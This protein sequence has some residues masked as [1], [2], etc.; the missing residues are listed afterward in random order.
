VRP[1]LVILFLS[2]LSHSASYALSLNELQGSNLVTLLDEDGDSA[3]WI[4]LFNPG[5][6]DLDLTDYGLSDREDQPFRWIFPACL[7]PADSTIL[8]FASGK[9]RLFWMPH[10]ETILDHHDL[11]KYKGGDVEPPADWREIGFDDGEWDEGPTGIGYGDG[12]DDTIISW[13]IKTWYTRKTFTVDE[14]SQVGAVAFHVDYDDG[15]VAYL[16]GV[17]I[18]RG[19]MGDPGDPPPHDAFAESPREATIFLGNRPEAKFFFDNSLLVEGENVLA[20]QVHNIDIDSMDLSLI[21]FLTLGMLSE[22]E[23]AR[24]LSET[25]ASQVPQLHAS[26]ELNPG[27]ESVFLTTPAGVAL[28]QA[29]LPAHGIDHS[30]G[31]HPDGV[32][33]WLIFEEPS[34]WLLN[35]PDGQA[36]YASPPEF[37]SPGGFYSGSVLVELGSEGSGAEIRYS[38]DSSDPGEMS[39]IY[40]SPIFLDETTVLRARAFVA[41]K[42]PSA[43]I[44][45]TYFF[46]EGSALPVISL[47]TDPPNL[48]DE[49]IGIY[50]L[51]DDYYPGFPYYGANFWQSWER[52]IHM[53]YFEPGGNPGFAM[54]LGV[55]IHGGLTRAFSQKS[56]RLLARQGYGKDHIEYRL[57]P[58]KDLDAFKRILLRNSGNDWCRSMLR[59][60]LMH[61]AAAGALV[62]RMAY[63]PAI[64]FLNGEYW[65]IHN[66]RERVGKFYLQENHGVDPENVDIL[67]FQYDVVDGDSLHYRAML[68]FIEANGLADSSDYAYIKTQMDVDE[69]TDYW[70]FQV[71]FGNTDWPAGNIKFWR[72]R[73]PGGIWRWLLFDTDFGLGFW[74]NY[75]FDTL[76]WSTAENGYGQNRPW[77]T[78]L[79]RQL[80][81][82]EEFERRFINRYSDYLNTRFRAERF[83]ALADSLKGIIE[84]EIARH[85]ERWDYSYESWQADMAVVEEFIQERP[86]AARGHLRLKFGFFEDWTLS[87][88]VQPPGSGTIQLEAIEVN[89]PWSGDY[90]LGN[91]VELTALPSPGFYFTGWSEDL[92]VE[93]TA[94]IEAVG[95]SSLVA[96]FAELPGRDILIHEIN[97]NSPDASDP[98]DWVELHNRGSSHVDISGWIFKDS[99]DVHVFAIP[100]GETLA[101]GAYIVL[102]E[103]LA[104]FALQFPEV[105]NVIGSL[106]FGF[107]GG[108]EL[109][110]LFDADSILIDSVEYEDSPPWPP[111]ADGLGPT[112]ELVSPERD[113]SLPE[114][115]EAS[116]LPLGTPG[117]PN[118]VSTES[119]ES[120][121]PS[122]LLLREPWPNPFNPVV[123]F[124]FGLPRSSHV[125]MD[126]YDLRGARVARILDA[127]M[128]AGF[129]VL[130]WKAEGQASGLYF[131]RLQVD[132]EV[133][134][135]KLLLL[136]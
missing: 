75:Q 4:E 39:E 38:I 76:A 108:G 123:N 30:F 11:V 15:Y 87:L 90:F 52:P 27:G 73:S 37:S 79:V 45:Q 9:D 107:S 51:G 112:L 35:G 110:R 8:V 28:D 34:P 53:E 47:A 67:E 1:L 24:G 131:A 14:L 41:G 60:G 114:S 109:L 3:D 105:E 121:A 88:D 59:D 117:A 129:H 64:V 96:T 54:D 66:I 113:N 25:L 20:V 94:L 119:Q 120:T 134:T 18:S 19:H 55:K 100:G 71:F 10:W 26:F 99:D 104:D 124:R 115:W 80:L 89:G 130:Q 125:R 86:A 101:P 116:A 126:I 42:A 91:P 136:K 62:D 21:P 133:R 106:G 83:Q 23:G 2:L 127:E 17:E 98:G 135:R 102:A 69:F 111:E 16:N 97:Y 12:D 81:E 36:G 50:V 95:D 74:E 40:E 82:N 84:P 70:V 72:P 13:W 29:N 122:A 77:S 68:D 6:A 61:R 78:F 56:L 46:G 57:F 93:D 103:D 65:G 7:I 85:Q 32:G 58:E 44:T 92:L 49:Q 48:W 22:P 43:I 132:G 31:R 33:P 63:E 128:D 118:S 5:P